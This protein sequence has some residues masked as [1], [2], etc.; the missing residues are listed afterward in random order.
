MSDLIERLQKA[1]GP[2]RELDISIYNFLNGTDLK[3]DPWQDG[4]IPGYTA[5]VNAALTLRP[6]DANCYGFDLGP[7]EVMGYVSRNNVASGHWVKEGYHAT[8]PAIALCIA[9][10]KARTTEPP[11]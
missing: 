3:E 11:K 5:S 2:D 7:N 9:A 1:V 8:S 4:S 6:D 10:L